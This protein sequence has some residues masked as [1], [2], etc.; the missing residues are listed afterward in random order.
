MMNILSPKLLI[1]LLL[2]LAFC[3]A[4][5]GQFDDPA[6]NRPQVGRR[7]QLKRPN[8]LR[9]LGL[10]TEQ[11][12][13]IR[14]MN[15]ERKP[16]VDA[17]VKRLRDANRALDE[18]IYSDTVDEG[19]FQTR[20]KEAS[21]AQNEVMRLRFQ[22]ELAVRKVLTP[23]QLARFRELRRQFAP[24]PGGIEPP[25]MDDKNPVPRRVMRRIP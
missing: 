17:A 25:G 7:G 13:Q 19:L 21:L 9:I 10:S 16:Q 8:L 5:L 3:G 6:P 11:A 18:A 15:Q 2:T 24:P 4:A 14:R 23:D 1:A 20:L 22:S 12:Q